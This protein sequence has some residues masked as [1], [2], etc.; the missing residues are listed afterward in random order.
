M[1]GS[2]QKGYSQQASRHQSTDESFLPQ[3]HLH[4]P[5]KVDGS[6][7]NDEVRENG[8]TCAARKEKKVSS[9]SSFHKKGNQ[10][11]NLP[12]CVYETT[13]SI[14]RFQQPSKCAGSHNPE[15]GLHWARKTATHTTF[16]TVKEPIITYKNLRNLPSS[17]IR[18]RKMQMETLVRYVMITKK[19]LDS[20]VYLS[21]SMVWARSR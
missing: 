21:A 14:L 4:I 5:E 8:K 6:E 17:G 7:R 11:R 2:R 12:P 19:S 20:C 13:N 18:M 16:T 10:D 15:I 3:G 1:S 9:S